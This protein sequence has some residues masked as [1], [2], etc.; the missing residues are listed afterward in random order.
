MP[1]PQEHAIEQESLTAT[2]QTLED[3]NSQGTVASGP[4]DADGNSFDPQ[5]HQIDS[6]GNPKLTPTGKLRK[7]RKPAKSTVA[8]VDI[9]VQASNQDARMAATASVEAIGM[10]GRMLGG[11]EWAFIRS[12]EHGID[13]KA[14]GIDA[15]TSYYNAKGVTDVPPGV[16][17][18]I[19]GLSYAGPRFAMPKTKSRVRLAADW[20]RTKISRKRRVRQESEDE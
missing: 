7:K 14:A 16:L 2:E 5:L 20:V 11:E 18:A 10:A 12:V 6:E 4:R 19:W 3:K 9:P 13:E 8:Q 1:E 17:L 15:F